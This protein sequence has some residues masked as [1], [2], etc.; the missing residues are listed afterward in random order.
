MPTEARMPD[1]GAQGAEH[2]Q[3]KGG[4]EGGR[5]ALPHRRRASWS[6]GVGAV[7]CMALGPQ[8]TLSCLSA[9]CRPR[10]SHP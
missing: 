3:G 4:K 1:K 5:E 6:K 9:W 10:N 2:W 8:P 7:L